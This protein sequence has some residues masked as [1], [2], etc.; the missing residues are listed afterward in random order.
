MISSLHFLT[1][2]FF[3]INSF[4]Q[5][6]NFVIWIFFFANLSTNDLGLWCDC[7]DSDSQLQAA[8]T[9]HTRSAPGKQIAFTHPYR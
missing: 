6:V 1:Q 4:Y 5:N 3:F 9:D 2:A 7:E 8:H